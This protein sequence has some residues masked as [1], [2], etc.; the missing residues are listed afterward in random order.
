MKNIK[1]LNCE[2]NQL[3]EISTKIGSLEMLKTFKLS[4]NPNLKVLPEEICRCRNLEELEINYTSICKL[5]DSL[6]KL[7]GLR[8]LEGD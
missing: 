4:Y 8:V 5:P 7:E 3:E 2:N 1:Y 6:D